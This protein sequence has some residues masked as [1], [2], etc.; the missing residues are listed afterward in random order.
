MPEHCQLWQLNSTNSVRIPLPDYK[1]YLTDHENDNYGDPHYWLLDPSSIPRY[2]VCIVNLIYNHIVR[3]EDEFGRPNLED[4]SFIVLVFD[5]LNDPQFLRRLVLPVE[6]CKIFLPRLL[7]T[8]GVKQTALIIRQTDHVYISDL[9]NDFTKITEG[10]ILEY[11]R[12]GDNTCIGVHGEM[13]RTERNHEGGDSYYLHVSFDGERFL[14][15]ETKVEKVDH[16]DFTREEIASCCLPYHMVVDTEYRHRYNS[17]YR[18]CRLMNATDTRLLWS[19]TMPEKCENRN[20]PIWPGSGLLRVK[21]Y[22]LVK[23]DFLMNSRDG[24]GIRLERKSTFSKGS[25]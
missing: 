8:K 5:Q 17:S 21:G 2:L 3:F 12:H 19:I 10:N 11:M 18:N 15:N 24:N 23:Q 16:T 1:L 7:A 14:F 20:C 25:K 9:E 6:R 4:E 22:V 13:Y